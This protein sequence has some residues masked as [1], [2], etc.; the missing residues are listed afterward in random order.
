[1]FRDHLIIGDVFLRT[2]IVRSCHIG[3]PFLLVR[4]RCEFPNRYSRFGCGSILFDNSVSILD[5]LLPLVYSA[6]ERVLL[7]DTQT[8]KL[9]A[10]KGGWMICSG[11]TLFPLPGYT[12]L[13]T[14]LI[15]R[16]SL[17]IFSPSAKGWLLIEF[18]CYVCVFFLIVYLRYPLLS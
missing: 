14:I 2:T 9:T 10:E 12:M 1:M 18:Q 4:I 15:R 16:R 3:T 13:C 17:R 5:L 7:Y 8:Q 6:N 11:S